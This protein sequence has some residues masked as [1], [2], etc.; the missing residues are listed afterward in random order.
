MVN[1]VAAATLKKKMARELCFRT[2]GWAGSPQ[3]TLYSSNL[4]HDTEESTSPV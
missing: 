2:P 4:L 3:G 1:R